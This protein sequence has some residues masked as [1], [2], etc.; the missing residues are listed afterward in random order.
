M[1]DE[2]QN[3]H[4][5]NILKGLPKVKAKDDFENRLMKRLRE[6]DDEK[7]HSPALNK[8]RNSEKRFS[9][10]GLLRPSL[11]PA[12]GLTIVLL[13]FIAY[14]INISI[15]QKTP[16]KQEISQN[17]TG[18][19]KEVRPPTTNNESQPPISKEETFGNNKNDRSV[20]KN[21]PEEI[22]GSDKYAP[23]VSQPERMDDQT[24]TP[25]TEEKKSDELRSV[26][27]KY[28]NVDI[29]EKKAEDYIRSKSGDYQYKDTGKQNEVNQEEKEMDRN[30]G[31]LNEQHLSKDSV[32]KNDSAKVST[33]RDKRA[34]GKIYN[35]T[36]KSQIETN[37]Q[38]EDSTN[39]KK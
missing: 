5:R 28:D 32:S 35:D 10:S 2:N 15:I 3:N 23:S 31:V 37:E 27:K 4:L 9:L 7:Y 16:V 17:E 20:Y 25:K 29:K 14:Y 36:V 8:L 13:I 39:N 22:I 33:K 19:Q 6:V 24:L 1:T 30:D 11:A 21:A 18:V 38:T 26:E 34:K 12:I